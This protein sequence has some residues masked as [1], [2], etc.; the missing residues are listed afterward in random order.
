MVGLV[1]GGISLIS[2]GYSAY[3]ESEAQ[4]AGEDYQQQQLDI[5]RQQQQFSAEQL[6]Q[7]QYNYQ[8]FT[9]TYGEL[10]ENMADYYTNLSPD[11]YSSQMNDALSS[12]F[13]QAQTQLSADMAV[14]GIS[15]S[16]VEAGIA[17]DMSSELATQQAT[18]DRDAPAWVAEKQTNLY[19][20]PVQP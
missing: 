5:A 13:D 15:G 4:S 19:N 7:E 16:G 9:N 1:L 2:A 3:Q 14:R 18:I 17:T 12:R 10:A 6:A 8:Q 20:Q 11:V